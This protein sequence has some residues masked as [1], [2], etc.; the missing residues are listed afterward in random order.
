MSDRGKLKLKFAAV[1]LVGR[2]VQVQTTN[3]VV[4]EGICNSVQLAGKDAV[5]V[6]LEMAYKK[7]G[8]TADAPFSV[9]LE[10]PSRDRVIKELV[11]R[12]SEV[13]QI[14][15]SGIDLGFKP[16]PPPDADGFTDTGISGGHG[17]AKGRTL[18][19]WEGDASMDVDLGSTSL[20]GKGWSTED[21]FAKNA[22]FGVKSTWDENEY[23]TEV[24]TSAPDY[25]R[26]RREADRLA[27][28][29]GK[30]IGMKSSVNDNIHVRLDRGHSLGEG[31]TEDQLFSAVEPL[32]RS[33]PNSYKPPHAAGRKPGKPGKPTSP[34]KPSGPSKPGARAPPPGL[35]ASDG[36]RARG[37]D[38]AVPSKASLK[39]FAGDFKLADSKPGSGADAAGSEEGKEGGAA[40]PA[41]KPSFKLNPDAAEFSFNPKAKEFTPP[42]PKPQPPSPAMVQQQQQQAMLMQQ[43]M[44][45]QQYLYQQAQ[46]ASFGYP[47]QMMSPGMVQ[48]RGPNGQIGMMPAGYPMQRGLYPGQPMAQQ[49]QHGAS[50]AVPA[51]KPGSAPDRAAPAPTAS[52]PPPAGP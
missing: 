24:D 34:V 2:V 11:I 3:G 29:M 49:P 13:A 20:S 45:M 31:M 37:P 52:A 6:A 17:E 41:K 23:T 7:I 39:A 33:K 28:E 8:S 51:V 1:N 40:T 26:R 50:P 43:R 5:G 48:V 36:E 16:P 32:A 44:Q 10:P 4:Y 46:A 14:H 47:A 30:G 42:A 19:M 21:M 27:R 18:E 9:E 22:E 25:E 35:A 15:A 38:S 12:G